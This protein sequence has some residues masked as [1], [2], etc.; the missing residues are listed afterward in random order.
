[1]KKLFGGVTV[2]GDLT[3]KALMGPDLDPTVEERWDPDKGYGIWGPSFVPF[4]SPSPRLVS[5]P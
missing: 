2:V 1:M 3:W 5:P 4:D